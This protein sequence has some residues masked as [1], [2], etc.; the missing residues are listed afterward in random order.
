MRLKA[1]ENLAAEAVRL[2]RS[3]GL[4][5]ATVREEGLAGAADEQVARTA[6]R[7]ERTL[8]TLDLGFGSP[9]VAKAI[10]AGVVVMRLKH[11]TIPSQLRAATRL[12]G[13]LADRDPAGQV[14]ILQEDRLRIHQLGV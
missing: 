3:T 6:A 14:W 12:A 10:H 2:L 5:V 11:Q 9:T 1:D 4:D 13:H 8:V 7:E